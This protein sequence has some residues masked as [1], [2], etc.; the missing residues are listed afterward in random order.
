MRLK[1]VLF[2]LNTA[3]S[4]QASGKREQINLNLFNNVLLWS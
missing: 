3:Q 2:W 4:A 1:I